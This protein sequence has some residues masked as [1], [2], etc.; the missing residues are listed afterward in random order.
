MSSLQ[1]PNYLRNKVRVEVM[2]LLE[3]YDKYVYLKYQA[4]IETAERIAKNTGLPF[5]EIGETVNR[6]AVR[7]MQTSLIFRTTVEILTS[8]VMAGTEHTR[9]KLQKDT[10]E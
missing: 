6:N 5:T 4:L 9:V 8:R 7:S 3:D 10:H 2:N 1:D